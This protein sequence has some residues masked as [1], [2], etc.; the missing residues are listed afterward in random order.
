MSMIR[1]AVA[2]LPLTVALTV[3]WLPSLMEPMPSRRPSQRPGG[4]RAR[5]PAGRSCPVAWADR[6]LGLPTWAP[7]SFLAVAGARPGTLRAGSHVKLRESSVAAQGSASGRP[8]RPDL[9]QAARDV[10]RRVVAREAR[11]RTTV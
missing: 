3:T 1:V 8:G 5:R 4:S 6:V 2:V 11:V 7:N 10:S 9:G